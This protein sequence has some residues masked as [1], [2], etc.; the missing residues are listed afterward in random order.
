MRRVDVVLLGVRD[1]SPVP[2]SALGVNI[3]GKDSCK[4]S[5]RP[6][7]PSKVYNLSNNINGNNKSSIKSNNYSNNYSSN[8]SNSNKN[9]DAPI[10]KQLGK[11][12]E[13][14]C[15][16][17]KSCTGSLPKMRTMRQAIG[18]ISKK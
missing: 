10:S 18:K 2:R 13:N 17:N 14:L 16:G 15:G 5:Q 11:E 1:S 7:S 4:S 9:I 12:K 3:S 8:V 6:L